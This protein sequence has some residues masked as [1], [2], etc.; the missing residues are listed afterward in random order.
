VRC[1]ES[2][3][4]E[5]IALEI[6]ESMEQK[7]ASAG[8]RIAELEREIERLDAQWR[9]ELRIYRETDDAR[10]AELEAEVSGLR[11]DAER[12]RKLRGMHWSK[13]D[14]FTVTRGRSVKLG[15]LA[16]SGEQLD[17][18]IDAARANGGGE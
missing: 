15:F 11:V 14:D 13:E 2:K 17:A 5:R 4:D 1:E 8:A 7:L 6:I 3:R 9:D 12:W 16:Y 18:A 10:I